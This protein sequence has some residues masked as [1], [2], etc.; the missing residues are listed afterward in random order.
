LRISLIAFTFSQP[1][2]PF[3]CCDL[4]WEFEFTLKFN[5]SGTAAEGEKFLEKAGG[6]PK[7][8][9]RSESEVRSIKLK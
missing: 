8:K 6:T 7:G 1:P 2:I 9:T 5:D 3:S 4:T